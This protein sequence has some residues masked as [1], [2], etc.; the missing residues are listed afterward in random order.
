M[1]SPIL[2]AINTRLTVKGVETKIGAKYLAG[3]GKPPRVVWVP[4][5]RESKQPISNGQNPKTLQTSQWQIEAH[6]WGATLE[7]AERIEQAVI[8]DSRNAGL[9]ASV[10]HMHTEPLPVESAYTN[11]GYVLVVTMRILTPLPEGAE[12]TLGDNTLQTVVI[13]A[14]GFEGPATNVTG[15]GAL[16][17]E[18]TPHTPEL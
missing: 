18:P 16:S 11:D 6:C 5:R 17:L 14:V 3:H 15:D 4:R 7:D 9:G 12:T 13:A 8:T 2:A 10:E 1:L